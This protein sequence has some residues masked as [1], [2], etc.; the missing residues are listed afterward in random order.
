MKIIKYKLI[1]IFIL[2]INCKRLG[3]LVNNKY[4]V[5]FDS[6]VGYNSWKLCQSLMQQYYNLNQCHNL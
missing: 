4:Y 6:I 1:I 5:P 2:A 3:Q